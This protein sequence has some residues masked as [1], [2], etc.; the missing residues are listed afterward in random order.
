MIVYFNPIVMHW[1]E[2]EERPVINGLNAVAFNVGTGIILWL[3]AD[4]NG[5]T[6]GWQMS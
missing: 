5:L 6:G 3:M 2:P 4:I 1:F